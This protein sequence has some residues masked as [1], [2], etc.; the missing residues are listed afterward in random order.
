M[1]RSQRDTQRRNDYSAFASAVSQYLTNNNGKLP[2]N[3]TT[4]TPNKYLNSKGT[5][6]NGLEY[7]VTVVDLS[8]S[9]STVT[10]LNAVANTNTATQVYLYTH[11]DCEATHSQTGANKPKKVESNRAYAIY[12][13]LE[14]GNGTYCQA[15]NS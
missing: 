15:N 4:L 1:Q 5:D 10:E 7:V 2:T 8:V 13:Q 3:G 12:G 14:A 6:P 9:G 11:A